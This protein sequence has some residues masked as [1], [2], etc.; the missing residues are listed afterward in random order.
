M[1]VQFNPKYVPYLL[2][3]EYSVTT[4]DGRG[5]RFITFDEKEGH[6]L[7]FIEYRVIGD[8]ERETSS[9]GGYLP[10]DENGRCLSPTTEPLI[11]DLWVI[12]PDP[13]LSKLEQKVLE[14]AFFSTNEHSVSMA[15][16]LA[17]ELRDIAREEI[18]DS[19][20]TLKEYVGAARMEGYKDA[21]EQMPVWKNVPADSLF[22]GNF[23]GFSIVNG[24]VYADGKY[25]NCEDLKKL[26]GW[27]HPRK[28]A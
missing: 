19:D 15:K 14:V 25:I 13:E 4:N 11:N 22:F 28:E 20:E 26:P 8:C 10:F 17:A 27:E 1:R 24:V 2:S 12:V 6:Y 18:F 16:Q 7:F 9:D 21:I 5:A 3:G 23:S